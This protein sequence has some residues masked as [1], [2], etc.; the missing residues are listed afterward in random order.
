MFTVQVVSVTSTPLRIGAFNLQIYGEIKSSMNST[1]SI[2]AEVRHS[3]YNPRYNPG[4]TLVWLSR[5]LNRAA[6]GSGL[7]VSVTQAVL[8]F[9]ECN[10]QH[11]H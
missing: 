9:L 8:V 7:L 2:I 3:T 10:Y 4:C 1:V 6:K 11:H 5:P